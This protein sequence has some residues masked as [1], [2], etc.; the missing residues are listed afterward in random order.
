M[1]CKWCG[2]DIPDGQT[3]CLRCGKEQPPLAE[4]GGFY[5]L[6]PKAKKPES[7]GEPQ[8]EKSEGIRENP[9]H[10]QMKNKERKSLER[11]AVALA[12]AAFAV[13]IFSM[14]ST[15]K[16]IRQLENRIQSI[17][18]TPTEVYESQNQAS[19]SVSTAETD[20]TDSEEPQEELGELLPKK[21]IVAELDFSDEERSFLVKADGEIERNFLA[22]AEEPE[23]RDG[24]KTYQGKIL[25]QGNEWTAFTIE[26]SDAR[27][28]DKIVVRVNSVLDKCCDDLGEYKDSDSSIVVRWRQNDGDWTSGRQ[29]SED[30]KP[31][32]YVISYQELDEDEEI[33]FMVEIE[34]K[35]DN[36]GSLAILVEGL[37]F[38]II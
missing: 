17:P 34:R 26:I 9:P 23:E 31:G 25:Y 35:N 15:G 36:D 28:S 24:C 14:F 10:N 30:S 21:N 38:E 19:E 6:V 11:I 33:E 32:E 12:L 7:V 1:F 27:E 29:N 18:N 5:N 8:K 22:Y 16:K 13:A 2:T 37:L 4:C 20:H 3:I